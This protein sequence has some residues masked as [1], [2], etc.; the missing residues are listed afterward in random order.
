MFVVLWSILVRA[1]PPDMLPSLMT[2]AALVLA[3]VHLS[4]DEPLLLTC[5]RCLLLT[6]V[7]VG[8]VP[9]PVPRLLRAISQ[10]V[11]LLFNRP[12]TV[13]PCIAAGN[14]CT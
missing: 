7:G 11:L 1:P 14:S 10:L 6:V 13:P 2:H 12:P 3:H 9:Y 4:L 5:L 8:C